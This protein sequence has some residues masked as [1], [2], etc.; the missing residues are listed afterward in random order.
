MA[1]PAVLA[2]GGFIAVFFIMK[3]ATV[4]RVDHVSA[5]M[6]ALAGLKRQSVLVGVPADSAGRREETA[7]EPGAGT[8]PTNTITN[9]ELAYLH[10]FGATIGMPARTQTVYRAL[11]HSGEFARGGRFVKR[12][13]ATYATEHAVA[14][15]TITIPPRPFLEPGI[16]YAQDAIAQRMGQALTAAV[17]LK[18]DAV[19]MALE[20]A[21]LV[22]QR[23]V[24]RVFDSSE[25]FAPLA[26]STLASR[27]R[28]GRTGTKPLVDTAQLR[29]AITYVVRDH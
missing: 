2:T 7:M 23:A 27:R 21:G 11:K 14:A 22:A 5:L 9:A 12:A 20:A 3:N 29:N 28:R 4:T 25:G 17:A 24:M 13:K 8:P 1:R 19:R 15:Y 10:T 18:P 16:H 6:K 26:A